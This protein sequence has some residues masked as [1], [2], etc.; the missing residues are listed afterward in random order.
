LKNWALLLVVYFLLFP[1]ISEAR[2]FS[3]KDTWVSAYLRGTGGYSSVGNNAYDD[4]SG[5]ATAFQNKDG[6]KYNFSGEIGFAF[7]F[8]SRLAARLGVEG[9]ESKS[10]EANSQYLDVKSSVLAVSPDLTLEFSILN[11]DK[12]KLYIFAGAGYANTTVINE[13]AMATGQSQYPGAPATYK[14]TWKG[15]AISYSAGAGAE[16]FVLDN[17]TM[18]FEL[19]YRMLD[20]TDFTYGAAVTGIRGAATSNLTSGGKVKNN[21]GDAVDINLGG[22]FAGVIFKFYIPPLN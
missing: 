10:T 18:S 5:T 4:T 22:L 1:S 3:F 6:A 20:V 19:G 14:E 12:S 8:G 17:V 11:S 7:Q 13:Y 16:T 2:V 9:I 21:N 15:T